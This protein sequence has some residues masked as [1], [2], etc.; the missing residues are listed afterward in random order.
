MLFLAD[1]G[2][3]YFFSECLQQAARAEAKE[4]AGD[5]DDYEDV[6]GD[7]DAMEV[8]GVRCCHLFS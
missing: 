4:A 8:D 3:F 6:D 7:D 1:L 2:L 5:D